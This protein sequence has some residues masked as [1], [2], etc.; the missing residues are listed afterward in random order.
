MYQPLFSKHPLLYCTSI[1][2]YKLL[3]LPSPKEA[4]KIHSIPLQCRGLDFACPYGEMA[5]IMVTKRGGLGQNKI[6]P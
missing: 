3:G 5:V 6:I 2:F 4:N 1:P